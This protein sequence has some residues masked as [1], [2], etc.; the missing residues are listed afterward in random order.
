MTAIVFNI[1]LSCSISFSDGMSRSG[2]FITCI[3]EIERIKVE[4]GVDIFQTVKAARAQRPH[5]VYTSVSYCLQPFNVTLTSTLPICTYHGFYENSHNQLTPVCGTYNN[6]HT[7]STRGTAPSSLEIQEQLVFV[8]PSVPW[9][10]FVIV[11]N[12]KGQH[13]AR[14]G[15]HHVWLARPSWLRPWCL[16]HHQCILGWSSNPD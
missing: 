8:Q 3:T 10:S 6:S 15:I 11:C 12:N 13:F 16:P 5:M 2:V 14:H 7:K 1:C 9:S 4:G